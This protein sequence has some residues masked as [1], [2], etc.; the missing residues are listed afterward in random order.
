MSLLRKSAWVLAV[1]AFS[2]QP[3]LAQESSQPQ[4]S[5]EG[6]SESSS[7]EGLE[8]LP[9][10]AWAAGEK[11]DPVIRKISSK[12]KKVFAALLEVFQE[13]EIPIMLADPET[14]VINTELIEYSI[15]RRWGNLATKPV[16]MSRERPILQ[17]QG[18]NSGKVSVSA[19]LFKKRRS[20]EIVMSAYLEEHAK[21]YN[22]K[23]RIWVERYSNGKLENLILDKL[24]SKLD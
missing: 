21:H 3:L 2:F 18:L 11:P 1:C 20:T 8:N 17:R 22:I 14:G 5:A 12:R 15:K 9:A 19:T 23:E 13:L 16:E 4:V 7:E 6:S 10:A 24:E